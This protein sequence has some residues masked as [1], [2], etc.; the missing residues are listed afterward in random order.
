MN[1]FHPD[2][3]QEILYD[4][5]KPMLLVTETENFLWQDGV[6]GCDYSYRGCVYDGQEKSGRYLF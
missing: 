2:V 6:D 3:P 5:A 4:G 1:H